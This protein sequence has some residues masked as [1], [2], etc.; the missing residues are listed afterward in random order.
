MTITTTTESNAKATQGIS[1]VANV[2]QRLTAIRL[3]LSHNRWWSHD[4]WN[5]HCGSL[6]K[7]QPVLR[8]SSS[9]LPIKRRFIAR[10]RVYGMSYGATMKIRFLRLPLARH[11]KAEAATSFPS[12]DANRSASSNGMHG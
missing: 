8:F 10:E 5:N 12:W 3:L 9:L 7:C 1:S 4:T 6:D 2:S 11:L